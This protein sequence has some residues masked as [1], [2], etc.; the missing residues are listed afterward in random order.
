MR[1]ILLLCWIC[2]APPL[3]LAAMFLLTWRRFQEANA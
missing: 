3:Q 1:T 2:P